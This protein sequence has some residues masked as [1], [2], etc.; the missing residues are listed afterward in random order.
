M[1][2]KLCALTCVAF[3]LQLGCAGDSSHDG[4]SAVVRDSAGV[5]IVEYDGPLTS[6]E[7]VEVGEPV[8][9]HGSGTNHHLFDRIIA[10][11]LHPDGRAVVADAGSNEVVVLAPDGSAVKTLLAQGQGPNEVRGVLSVQAGSDDTVIVEDDGNGRILVLRD[12]SVVRSVRIDGMLVSG[13]MVLSMS[14]EE[15]LLMGTSSFRSDSGEGWIPG[16]MVRLELRSDPSPDTV[17]SYD[18]AISRPR[19]EPYNPF[20]PAGHLTATPDG[21]IH[22]RSDRAEVIWETPDGEVAQILRW[23]TQPTYPTE[24]D[25]KAYIAEYRT[26]LTRFNPGMPEERVQEM[27]D[28]LSFSLDQPVPLYQYLE[29]H[30]DGSLWMTHFDVRNMMSS[31]PREYLQV[32]ANGEVVRTVIFPDPVRILDASG[33]KVLG[34]VTDEMDVQHVVVYN[35]EP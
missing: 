8:Y 1:R 29:G 9:R 2:A 14:E 22:G 21:F 11:S 12:S 7:R 6:L 10:G 5:R 13:L 16:Y 4:T 26:M 31:E 30:S 20:G 27:V 35:L 3:L 15:N 25:L 34:V 33:G 32:S 19:G 23:S 24:E 18:M 28:D 17:G